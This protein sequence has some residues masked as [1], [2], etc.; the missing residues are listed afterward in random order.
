MSEQIALRFSNRNPDVLTC[1]ANLSSDEVFTPPQFA[2]QMLDVVEQ[3]WATSHD[4]E[5]IWTN[6]NV[7]FLDPFTKSGVFLR[8]ITSRLVR[9]LEGQIPDLQERVDHVLSHQVFGIGITQL[10]ALLA[11]RS[12]YCSK[13]ANG[14]HSI[15]KSFDTTEG[16]V[17]FQRVDHTWIGATGFV[18][19]ADSEGRPTQVGT[20]GR[21][22][23]CGANQ[24]SLDRSDDLE[25]HAYAFIHTDDV[26]KQ[27]QEMFGDDMQF[28]VIIGNPPYQLSDGGHS[29]SAVPIYQKFVE[30]AISL[31]PRLLCMVI[32]SRWFAGGRGLDSF[33][34]RMLSDR[35][36]R[37]ITDYVVEKDAFPG[38]NI[39]G[40]VNYFLW[41]RDS[42]GDCL[43]QTVAPGGAWEEPAE[44]PLNEFDIFV[45]RNRAISILRKVIAFKEP[46][47]DSNVSSLK[48]FGLRTHFHGAEKASKTRNIKFYGSGQVSWV[49][50]DEIVSNADWIDSWKVLVARA[51]DGN[52]NYPLPIWDQAGP[53]VAGPG[54]A[55]SETYLVA[56]RVKSQSEAKRTVAY[57]D[58]MFFRFLV[59]LRKFTQDNKADVFSFVP[60]LPMDRIWTDEAL[61]ERYSLDSDEVEF[62]NS[63]IR[64][65]DFT[66]A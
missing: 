35:R 61:F 62:I 25:T 4:D 20:N 14:V 24:R 23:F 31:E 6:P 12:L 3:A 66:N 54:E 53:F 55:C 40:G 50:R 21:C 7:R 10:T 44:R 29:A 36:I 22:K 38:V 41:N 27:L 13:Y 47:F 2:G 58:T 60:N 65:V 16:N 59:S 5:V 42:P 26:E 1:I 56:A 19:T 30:Q 43:V 28:D 17:W 45:R 34:S 33:R 32:P 57:M 39:N 51:T 52:E 15:T 11:R 49:S 48:P 64:Q 37:A 18:E 63:M 8:E 46:T 9:G